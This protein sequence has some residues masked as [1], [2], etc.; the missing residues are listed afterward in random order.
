MAR[1]HDW[2]HALQDAI[3]SISIQPSFTGYISKGIALCGKGHIRD[4]RAA[5]DVMFMYTDQDSETVHFLLLIKVCHSCLAY[6]PFITYFR[7]SPSSAQINMRKQTCSSKNSLL[8]VRML[9][10]ARVI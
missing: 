1:K 4:A 8:V 3:K 9:I 5:F 7:S 2:D 10:P 6:S